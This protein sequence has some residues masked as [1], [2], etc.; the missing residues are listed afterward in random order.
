MKTIL[1]ASVSLLLASSSLLMAESYQLASENPLPAGL[2]TKTTNTMSFDFKNEMD[3][4]EQ[5]MEVAMMMRGKSVEEL[6]VGA[7]DSLT[8]KIL[9]DAFSMTANLPGLGEQKQDLPRPL[10]G[11]TLTGTLSDGAWNLKLNEGNAPAEEIAGKEQ[12]LNQRAQSEKAMFGE[13]ARSVGDTWKFDPSKMGRIGDFNEFTG[14]GTATFVAIEEIDGAKCAKVVFDFK[15]KVKE[16]LDGMGE[17]GLSGKMT[18]WRDVELKLDR[19][20]E[21]K[22]KIAVAEPMPIDAPI[23]MTSKVEIL[24][25]K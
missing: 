23:T 9:E 5:V 15:A 1:T 8:L 2:H 7:A 24:G 11:S 14:E 21:F 16:G 19:S 13:E 4:G 20:R 18:V 17:T 6:K 10:A 12:E 22:G 25:T 3:M